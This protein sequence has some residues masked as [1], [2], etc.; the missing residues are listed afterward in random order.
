MTYQLPDEWNKESRKKKIIGI[1]VG[2]F[3]AGAFILI[4]ALSALYAFDAA[5]IGHP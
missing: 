3:G 4:M 1:V 2:A 5:F